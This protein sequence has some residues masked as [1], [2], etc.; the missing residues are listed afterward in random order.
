M[1]KHHRGEVW[2]DCWKTQ[3]LPHTLLGAKTDARNIPYR[4]WND[5]QAWRIKNNTRAP[6]HP[7][8][9]TIQNEMGMIRECWK[10]AMENGYCR[11]HPKLPFQD[12]NLITDDKVK[13]KPGN[14]MNGV[15]LL[16]WFR[17][18]LNAQYEGTEEQFWDAGFRIRWCFSL[19]TAGCVWG[20]W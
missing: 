15:P 10:W 9:I 8:A 17:E 14:P 18:W 1:Q 3:E 4:T 16:V 7:K 5:W 11:S 19:P 2:T 20:N 6:K 12:E 13:R